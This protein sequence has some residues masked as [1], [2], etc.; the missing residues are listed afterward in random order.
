MIRSAGCFGAV[1]RFARRLQ[2]G[3]LAA[4]LLSG[5]AGTLQSSGLLRG[6]PAGLT[7][8]VELSQVPF[9][10]Q[11]RYQCGPAALAT[12][13]SWSGASVSP[14]ELVPEVYLPARRGSLQLELAAAARRH[15]RVPYPLAGEVATLLREVEAGHPVLVL[16]NLGLSWYPRWH[17]AVI[18]GFD[19]SRDLIV[20][21]S[22]MQRREGLSLEVFERIWRRGGSWAITVTV[23]EDL[24]QTAAELPYLRAVLPFEETAQW[25]TAARA[26]AAAHRRWPHSIGAAMGLGNS[27]YALHDYPAA[28]EAFRSLLAEHPGYG[29]ALNNLAETL[30]ATGDLVSAEAYARAAVEA[31]GDEQGVYRQTLRSI[32]DRLPPLP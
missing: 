17:Y 13:L 16:E 32:Q 8:P 5:C 18:V 2:G 4:L 15:G 9:F 6:P 25:R 21:R 12:A 26:Y 31:G 20:L 1:A 22:G 11:Q 7:Q 24:P 10:P 27:R 23:P 29:P 14:D 3:V 28:A 19:L 30:A